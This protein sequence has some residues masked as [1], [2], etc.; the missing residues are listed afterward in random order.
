MGSKNKFFKTNI[1]RG[2]LLEKVCLSVILVSL[3][4]SC[5]EKQQE[6]PHEVVRPV[7]VMIVEPTGV[8]LARKYPG[9]VRAAQRVDLAFQVSGTLQELPVEEGQRVE[10]KQVLARLDPRDFEVNL[11]NAQGQLA[12]AQAALE[13]AQSEYE[14]ITGIRDKDPGA[15]SALTVDQKRE[16][17]DR[18]KA[19]I[20]SLKAAVDAAQLQLSY[21]YLKAPFSGVLSV[22]HVDNFEEVQAKQ[23]IVSLDDLSEVEIVVD[24]PEI[25]MTRV[26][27]ATP[28]IFAEFEAA[29][30][31]QYP[32]SIK[33]YSTRADPRTQTYRVVLRMPA[34]ED[35]NVLPGMT[36]V[37]QAARETK[38]GVD[39][40]VIPAIA[41]FADETSQ[42]HVWVVDPETSTV[43][44]RK[45]TTGDLTGTDSIQIL[46][47]I[48][49]GEMIAISAV[50][51]LREG[52]KI[53]PVE[54]IA[55]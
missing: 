9:S 28:E 2:T 21:T 19:E 27:A 13:L 34:P 6:I 4:T 54:K 10:E 45:V 18:A 43:L 42:A 12:K 48:K 5:S 20:Q 53:R 33:E 32:L 14:R 31:K 16:A 8:D 40:F 46:D 1:S 7:K 26:K 3:T 39:R 22:R 55:F 35:I 11:R 47:G 36:A 37:V 50:S 30:G 51:R 52:M 25:A 15:I 24:V 17:V 38:N 23:P 44:K 29:P 41:V 49:S